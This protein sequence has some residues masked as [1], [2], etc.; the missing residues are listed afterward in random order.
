[1]QMESVIARS[2]ATRRSPKK[3]LVP[4]RELTAMRIKGLS[5]EEVGAS[6]IGPMSGLN[7]YNSDGNDGV[8][9]L[10]RFLLS[11][12]MRPKQKTS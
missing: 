2:E 5:S 10:T 1:M 4:A 8:N 3:N 12:M 11:V 9:R 7:L 6:E